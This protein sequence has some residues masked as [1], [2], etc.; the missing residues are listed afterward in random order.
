MFFFVIKIHTNRSVTHLL[1]MKRLEKS[2]LHIR[3][4]HLTFRN[5]VT[6]VVLLEYFSCLS[7]DEATDVNKTK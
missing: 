3:E 2:I 6:E 1:G 7:S 5:T 4:R